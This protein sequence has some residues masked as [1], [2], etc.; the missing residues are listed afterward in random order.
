MKFIL[1]ICI[2][3]VISQNFLSIEDSTKTKLDYYNQLISQD[4]QNSIEKANIYQTLGEIFLYEE[5]L[6]SA[7][8][9]FSLS[10]N[11]YNEHFTN[12]R[13]SLVQ[14]LKKLSNVYSLTGDFNKLQKIS[15]QIDILNSTNEYLY[16]DSL[17]II[18]DSTLWIPF[19]NIDS[20]NADST[21]WFINNNNSS[22]QSL[23]LMELTFSYIK[24]G[25]YSEAINSF[26]NAL[27][28]E[29]TILDSE[30]FLDFY[31]IEEQSL[32][33]LINALTLNQKLDSLNIANNFFLSLCYNQLGNIDS[34]LFYMKRYNEKNNLD[35]LSFLMLANYYEKKDDWLNSLE[36]YQEVVWKDKNNIIARNGVA[37]SLYNLNNFNSA[38]AGYNN[39]LSMDPYHY[40]S[41]YYLGKI[42]IILE[43]YD[44]DSVLDLGTNKSSTVNAPKDIPRLEKIVKENMARRKAEEEDDDDDDDDF[45]KLTIHGG[46]SIKLKIDDLGSLDNKLKLNE[47]KL[48]VE[49][50]S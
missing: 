40:E 41:F 32:N 38:I 6:D 25:L 35:N 21:K 28:L 17:S 30:Y 15:N 29:S 42:N 31:Y 18:W 23:E 33:E 19:S 3:I 26:S 14:S 5:K 46:D 48:D 45:D 49:V 10:E 16:Y 39:I 1:I 27:S 20:L 9:Y 36:K 11:L 44:K 43:N 13:N 34:S 22:E 37:Y 47:P 12:S 24:N 4:F 7:Q 8:K 2:N 50:L